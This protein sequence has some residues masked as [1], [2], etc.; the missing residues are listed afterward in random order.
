MDTMPL[1]TVLLISL[2]EE[3]LL[4]AVGLQL[5]GIKLSFRRLV[6]IGA[7]QAM[8]SYCIRL[9]PLAFGIHTML[10]IPIFALVIWL[11]I[12]VPYLIA[13]TCILVSASFY[14]VIDA[15]LGPLLLHLTGIPLEQVLATPSLQILFFLPQGLI[16]FF[17]V[18]LLYF[19]DLKIIDLGSYYSNR[20]KG[21]FEWID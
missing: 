9:L 10:Q 3:I 11:I 18:L 13:L 16:V 15:T 6:L 19:Y 21:R 7:L 17:I 12:R 20:C 5:F 14:M 1:I 8:V 2:P 4:T